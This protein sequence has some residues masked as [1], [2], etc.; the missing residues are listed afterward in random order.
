MGVLVGGC[1][2]LLLLLLRC[3]V[4]FII[5]LIVP[6]PPLSEHRHPHNRPSPTHS[7]YP[8]T[9]CMS[10]TPTSSAPLGNA[11]AQNQSQSAQQQKPSLTGV[12]I[13]QRKG[14]AKATA[15]FEPEGA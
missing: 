3:S 10:H 14:Q 4:R 13:K 2:L 6:F 7:S 9:H 11:P 1:R 5:T 12:R 15:K 8:S